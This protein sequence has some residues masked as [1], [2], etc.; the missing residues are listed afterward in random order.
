MFN[1]NSRTVQDCLMV[2]IFYPPPLTSRPLEKHFSANLFIF[3]TILY[4]KGPALIALKNML[5]GF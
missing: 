5:V 1:P 4:Q 2:C 3:R